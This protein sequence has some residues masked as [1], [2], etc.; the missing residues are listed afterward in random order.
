MPRLR[1]YGRAALLRRPDIWAAEH[2]SPTSA[3]RVS[4]SANYMVVDLSHR[5]VTAK[6]GE[7]GNQMKVDGMCK[8]IL[9]WTIRANGV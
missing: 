3:R 7:D 9:G 5:L 1:R 8:I 6:L 2:R 4:R